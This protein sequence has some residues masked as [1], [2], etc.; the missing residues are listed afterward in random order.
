MN[1]TPAEREIARID[2]LHRRF[3]GPVPA[4]L[5]HPK[6][7]AELQA[8]HHASMIRYCDQ[9]IADYTAALAKIEG[10]ADSETKTIWLRST[11][12]NLEDMRRTKARHEAELAE[13][14]PVA[15]E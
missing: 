12:E 4:H 8:G 6:T 13:P 2:E 7:E 11:R 3:D 5:L 1:S 15:A 14:L 9:R 10:W